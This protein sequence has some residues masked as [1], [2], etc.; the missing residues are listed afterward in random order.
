MDIAECSGG[1]DNLVCT[2]CVVDPDRALDFTCSA[3]EQPDGCCRVV[4]YATNPSALIPQGRGA[5]AQV[6]YSAGP[7]PI[8]V[9]T[10]ACI[11][12]WPVNIRI[13]DQFNED[14]CACQSPGE[15]CFR[16]CGDIYPQDCIGGTCGAPTLL[17]RR[18]GRPV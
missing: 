1:E 12:L 10:D 18:R 9:V 15:V 14:L 11:D 8:P 2:Q 16:T 4:L 6:V 3:N 5:I 17:R 7:E 13:S